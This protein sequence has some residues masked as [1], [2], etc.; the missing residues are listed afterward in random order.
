MEEQLIDIAHVGFL[1]LIRSTIATTGA[2][3][4]KG[5]LMRFATKAGEQVSAI[6][7]ASIDEFIEAIGTVQ[8]PIAQVEGKAAHVGGG[9]FGLPRC[10][11]A[12]S[13]ASFKKL[14]GALPEV[15]GE[16]VIEYNKPGMA[17]DA[18]RV[19]NGSGVSPFCAVHQ[20][21]RASVAGRITIGG[22]P[23]TV[24]QLG[25]K[26]ASGKKAMAERWI[27]E[28]GWSKEVVERTLDTNMCCYG[29]KC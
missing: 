14:Y 28:G 24:Y 7:F 19:G 5:T 9:V 17:A 8:N 21:M 20:P 26:A 6:D 25:C 27:E 2:V 11:F 3:S 15:Y 22:K 13:I 29:V 23:V 18:L 4:A 12:Q 1:E 10:P 16:V